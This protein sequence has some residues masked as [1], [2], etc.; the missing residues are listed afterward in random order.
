MSRKT[1]YVYVLTVLFP[2]EYL[3]VRE[4]TVVPPK[5]NHISNCKIR[6]RHIITLKTQTF[7]KFSHKNQHFH[8]KTKLLGNFHKFLDLKTRRCWPGNFFFTFYD[9]IRFRHIITLKTP[10]FDKFSHK[11]Q[12]VHLKTKL[13]GNF[14]K[15]LDLKTRKYYPGNFLLTFYDKSKENC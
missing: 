6:F 13:L 5:K 10:T 2:G 12:N 4:E 9:K 7:D 3:C 11:N 8:L 14:H 15:F 1:R